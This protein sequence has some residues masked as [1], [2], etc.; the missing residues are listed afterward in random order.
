MRCFSCFLIRNLKD[1]SSLFLVSHYSSESFLQDSA[2][3]EDWRHW[4]FPNLL[5][6]LEEF[7]SVRPNAPLLMAQLSILQP[8]FYSIS[9][10]QA[11]YPNQ[12]H[13]TVAVVVY[14]T[15]GIVFDCF[16][17]FVLMVLVRV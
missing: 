17:K 16:L 3:Y 14:R 13:L 8:R 7:P 6:A 10:S 4:R 11:I 1:L 12:L 15:E 5:E 2:A 9:S